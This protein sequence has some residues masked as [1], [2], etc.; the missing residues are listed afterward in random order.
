MVPARP[1]ICA[2]STHTYRTRLCCMAGSVPTPQVR[3]PAHSSTKRD[4]LAVQSARQGTSVHARAPDP[5]PAVRTARRPV[6]R[7]R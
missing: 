7:W 2:V 6:H 1:D 5:A 3:L 4:N